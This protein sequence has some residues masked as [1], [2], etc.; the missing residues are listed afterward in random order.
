M[1]GRGGVRRAEAD[2]HFR[3]RPRPCGITIH[4]GQGCQLGCV[5]CYVPEMGFPKVARP[6]GLEP[7]ELAYALLSNPWVVPERT[8]AA[9]G[10]VTEPLLPQVFERTAGYLKAVREWLGLPSQVSTKLV[11]GEDVARELITADRNLSILVSATSIKWASKLEPRAPEPKLRLLGAATGTG[12]RFDLF[13]RPIIPG[14]TN[15][16]DVRELLSLAK[17][18]GFKGV[19]PGSLRVTPGILSKLREAGVDTAGLVG[20]V[21]KLSSGGRQVPIST[22]DIKEVVK[23]LAAELGLQ[24]LPSACAANAYSHRIKC[25]ACS[26]GPCYGTPELRGSEVT[27]FLEYFRVKAEDVKLRGWVAEVEVRL[28]SRPLEDLRI[29]GNFLRESLK[30]KVVLKTPK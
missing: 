24:Y 2:P 13:L 29:L 22:S 18:S 12:G 21:G 25:F 7:E 4:P 20:R 26:F 10:S 23:K 5:Y 27:E 1:L 16:G 15:E 6:Y 11:V 9:F 3:R 19:V 8:Y 14:V 30:L 17:E 28:P